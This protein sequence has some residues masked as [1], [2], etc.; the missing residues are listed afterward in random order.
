MRILHENKLAL[1]YIITTC[2]LLIFTF[3]SD[4]GLLRVEQLKTERNLIQSKSLKVQ[5]HNNT[6]LAQ[7]LSLNNN[8]DEME[9]AARAEL[10]LVKK[11][12][13]LFKFTN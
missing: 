9:K 3:F 4:R 11:D 2:L 5:N 10:D 12:E 8:I 6:L 13:I 7:S 1:F